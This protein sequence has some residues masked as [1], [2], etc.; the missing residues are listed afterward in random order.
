MS[1][2]DPRQAG[3]GEPGNSSAPES[4][5]ESG[6]IQDVNGNPGP[7]R[8][9]PVPQFTSFTVERL[10]TFSIYKLF[11]LGGVFS[12]IPFLILQIAGFISGE[13]IT[14][15]VDG[16]QT[17]L[18]DSLGLSFQLV[19]PILV[20]LLYVGF[21]GTMSVIGLWIYSNIGRLKLE[22]KGALKTTSEMDGFTRI[23]IDRLGIP[24]VFKLLTIGTSMV[25]GPVTLL[26]AIMA[27]FGSNT[28]MNNQVALHGI[29]GFAMGGFIGVIVTSMIVLVLFLGCILGLGIFSL[30]KPLSI[31]VKSLK[32]SSG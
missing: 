21:F 18:P 1:T 10:G 12:V 5:G 32:L 24:S 30:F 16:K 31:E 25:L 8:G 11:F 4:A 3:G 9:Q 23:T 19:V 7:E 15:L 13:R 29:A 2:K 6:A 17:A 22:C 26:F 20:A 28:V 14:F 27:L